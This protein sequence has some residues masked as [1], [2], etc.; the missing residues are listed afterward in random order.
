MPL[1]ACADASSAAKPIAAQTAQPVN[2]R[3]LNMHVLLSRASLKFEAWT[4]HS[5]SERVL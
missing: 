3:L 5:W 1:G 2:I 4:R